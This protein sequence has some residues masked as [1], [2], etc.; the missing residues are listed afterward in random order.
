MY[1]RLQ[2]VSCWHDWPPARS[3]HG[4]E[5]DGGRAGP[6][7]A[8]SELTTLTMTRPRTRTTLPWKTMAAAAAA[9]EEDDTRAPPPSSTP[10]PHR[11]GLLF[12]DANEEL[13]PPRSLRA[14][15]KGGVR[16]TMVVDWA[17]T[18]DAGPLLCRPGPEHDLTDRAVPPDEPC[19]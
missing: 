6:G 2:A 17:R 3:R 13:C 18:G 1:D 4:P 5:H 7:P 15:A 9:Q 16:R 19:F 14:L 8:L 12:S 10:T 11:H